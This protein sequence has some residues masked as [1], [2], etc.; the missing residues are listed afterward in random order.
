M[1]NHNSEKRYLPGTYVKTETIAIRQNS[2]LPYQP[3]HIAKDR[4]EQVKNFRKS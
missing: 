4:L 2:S 1:I 3:L